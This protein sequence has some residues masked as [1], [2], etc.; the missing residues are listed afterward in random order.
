MERIKL[1]CEK[2][3]GPDSFDSFPS[4]VLDDMYSLRYPPVRFIAA[5]GTK[6]SHDEVRMVRDSFKIATN[7]IEIDTLIGEKIPLNWYLTDGLLLIQYI[8]KEV[9][10][11][12]GAQELVDAFEPY[13]TTNKWYDQVHDLIIG[14]LTLIELSLYDFK[15]GSF[16]TNISQLATNKIGTNSNCIVLYRIKP[17]DS[18]L[19]IDGKLR[20]VTPIIYAET[21]KDLFPAEITARQIGL[22]HYAPDSPMQ[23]YIQ[24]HAFKRL[25]ERLGFPAGIIHQHLFITFKASKLSRK[26]EQALSKE[27]A[28]KL[29]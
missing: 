17:Q 26:G 20:T 24:E 16:T 10:G 25:C 21:Q 9:R 3:A 4:R 29:V 7:E 11:F 18:A 8:Q 13:F 12:K 1:L 2:F 22:K 14:I 15:A 28:G 27:R 6:I 19:R 5:P 23:V